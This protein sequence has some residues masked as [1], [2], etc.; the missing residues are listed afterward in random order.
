VHVLSQPPEG[1]DGERGRID[2][3]LLQ[4][5][6]PTDVAERNVLVC[7]PPEMT[8]AARTA[9]RE[10]GVPRGRLHVEDFARV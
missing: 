6:L 3:A 4:R 8:A 7:G 2:A 9:L 1:W 5:V 10:Q